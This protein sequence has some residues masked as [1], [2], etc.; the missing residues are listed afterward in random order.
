MRPETQPTTGGRPWQRGLEMATNGIVEHVFAQ[1]FGGYGI[2]MG[3]QDNKSFHLRVASNDEWYLYG[4]YKGVNESPTSAEVSATTS[5]TTGSVALSW[6]AVSGA[7]GYVIYRGSTA[8]GES[9]FYLSSTQ[10]VH[11]H[12]SCGR[13]GQSPML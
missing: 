6:P 4:S 5:G 12:R 3:G 9:A 7:N 13:T 2:R 10:F 1:N 11:R 8:G